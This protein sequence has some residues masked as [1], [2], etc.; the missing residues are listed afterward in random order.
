MTRRP[1]YHPP[2]PKNPVWKKVGNFYYA[3]KAEFEKLLNECV[4]L[5]SYI[6]K[7]L[8]N[9]YKYIG[10]VLAGMG[11]EASTAVFV[12]SALDSS[13]KK[14]DHYPREQVYKNP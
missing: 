9:A 13:L 8:G 11:L 12:E 4:F 1:Q 7:T 14:N 5:D 6:Q 10:H 2:V 3:D